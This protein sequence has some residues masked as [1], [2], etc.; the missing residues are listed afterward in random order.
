MGWQ[1]PCDTNPCRRKCSAEGAMGYCVIFFYIL[2]VI[3]AYCTWMVCIFHG[4]FPVIVISPKVNFTP[5]LISVDTLLGIFLTLVFHV[6]ALF[7]VFPYI[8]CVLRSPGTPP[9]EWI[10]A[11]RSTARDALEV[12]RLCLNYSERCRLP[13]VL[14]F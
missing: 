14:Q 1:C 3:S 7:Q 8:A 10:G 12:S 2:I 13:R 9:T 4:S 11:C 5:V 6:L